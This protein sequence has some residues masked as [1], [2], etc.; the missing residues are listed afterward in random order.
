MLMSNYLMAYFSQPGH[1]ENKEIVHSYQKWILDVINK[2]VQV[3]RNE[4]AQLW[5]YERTGILYPQSL[6]EDQGHD[7]EEAMEDILSDTWTD[8]VTVCGIEMHR[9][10]LS[11]AHNADFEEISDISIRAK[12]E[13]RNLLM[14][15]DLILNAESITKPKDLLDIAE[16]YNRK[17]PF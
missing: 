2:T 17:D 3:F 14:G 16:S 4:F 8:A 11:L 9:R 5:R 15:R 6:F 7:S 1:R 12:L 10:C 13:A